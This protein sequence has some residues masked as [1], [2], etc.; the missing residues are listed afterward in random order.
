VPD[1]PV[2]RH[3]AFCWNANCIGAFFAPLVAIS[4]TTFCCL[5]L[6][7]ELLIKMIGHV[8]CLAFN[9]KHGV[10]AYAVL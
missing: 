1:G 6:Q 9:S 10:F 8:S 3:S 2:D 4:A 7:L 5:L